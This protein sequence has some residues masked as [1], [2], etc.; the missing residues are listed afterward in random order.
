MLI[1]MVCMVCDESVSNSCKCHHMVPGGEPEKA[2]FRPLPQGRSLVRPGTFSIRTSLLQRFFEAANQLLT[3]RLSYFCM[4]F[5]E[6]LESARHL[7]FDLSWLT[8]P[9]KG[10]STHT[11]RTA[12]AGS[13]SCCKPLTILTHDAFVMRPK[14]SSRDPSPWGGASSPARS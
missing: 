6:I 12:A 14:V 11:Q 1:T 13:F 7:T 8:L 3:L 4:A 5:F 2:L 9:F 10:T